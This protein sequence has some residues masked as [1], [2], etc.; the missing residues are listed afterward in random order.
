MT[1]EV[2]LT[3][4]GYQ[5][6]EEELELLVTVRRREVADK[7]KEAISYGDISENAEYD[8]AKND[9][10]ELEERINKLED[11]LRKAIIIEEEEISLDSVNVG[12]KVRV[13]DFEYDE[14]VD[15]TI[16]GATE[17]DPFEDKISNESPLGAALIGK[18]VGEVIEVTAPQG[19]MKY[20]VLEIHR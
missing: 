2:M 11:I 9:Q 12:V 1:N 10:A 14:I 16:V 19:L 5:K 17:A 15:Y 8:S 7:I 6:I 13:K 3:R 4:E 18:T 20:E